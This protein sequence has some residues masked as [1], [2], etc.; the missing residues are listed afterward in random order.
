[1][2]PPHDQSTFGDSTFAEEI[3]QAR[4]YER[5][6]LVKA[7]AALALVALVAVLHELSLRWG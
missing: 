1:M 7:A 3:E 6:L 2:N 4:R 5:G